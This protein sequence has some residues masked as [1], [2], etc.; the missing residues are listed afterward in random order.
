MPDRFFP[1]DAG[2]YTGEEKSRGVGIGQNF[3]RGYKKFRQWMRLL[4]KIFE[5]PVGVVSIMVINGRNSFSGMD[6]LPF[7][8]GDK[9]GFFS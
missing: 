5:E 2:Q 7:L 9:E 1:K 3:Y 4:L 8:K 6:Y